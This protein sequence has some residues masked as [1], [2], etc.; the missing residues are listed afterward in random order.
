MMPDE[1]GELVIIATLSEEEAYQV[2]K[3]SKWQGLD[4]DRSSVFWKPPKM[5]P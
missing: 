1:T 2:F 5:L 3:T 4:V